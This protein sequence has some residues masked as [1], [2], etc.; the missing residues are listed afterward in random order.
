MRFAKKPVAVAVAL[1]GLLVAGLAGARSAPPSR[2]DAD[3]V[4][5]FVAGQGGYASYRIPAIVRLPNGDLLA[6]AEG[7]L[8]GGADYGDVRILM[9]R[10]TDGGRSWSAAQVVASNG[11]RQAGNAA[12]VVDTLDPAWPRGRIFLF[13]NTGDAPED[14]V[15]NGKGRREIWYRTSVDDGR[16]WSAPVNISS[17]VKPQD[18]R[19]YANTPGHAIQLA[20]GRYK[21][22]IYIAA[23]HSAGSPQPNFGDLRSHAY[24]TDD[25]G[26]T[27]HLAASLPVPGS[28]E[29]TA[30]E[31]SGDG[32]MLN[33][34]NQA[35][36]PRTRI[37]AISDDG[38][39]HWPTVYYDR[40]L[41]DPV[42][43]GS[44]LNIG[45]RDSKAIL[46]FANEANAQQRRDLTVR[47]SFDDGKTWPQHYLVDQ[48]GAST[49]YVDLVKMGEHAVGV[50]YER[51]DYAQIVF[52]VV[53]WDPAVAP[54][55]PD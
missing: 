54:K 15:R 1:V 51:H 14:S 35:G 48:P 50:L 17:E 34:R 9:K 29:A 26:K 25:H 44:L 36:W 23:N 13:Y 40:Q 24:Y 41:P 2:P 28:N 20:H 4:P 39:M 31:L 27:F 32:V 45:S 38:G 22:R 47:I 16:T 18:W 11:T 33:V 12:P 19:T 37:V 43:E 53:H 42:S 30:A 6:F 8:T 52:R 10:S 46:A 7:R 3:A 21:G 5:V 49:A 55:K